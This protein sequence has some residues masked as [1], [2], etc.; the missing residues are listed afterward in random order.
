MGA[1]GSYGSEGCQV[2][3]SEESVTVLEEIDIIFDFFFRFIIRATVK[4]LYFIALL[5]QNIAETLL[6]ELEFHVI[7][8]YYSRNYPCFGLQ[9]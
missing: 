4:F 6:P 3:D 9:Y 5:L 7:S 1:E 8:L 2:V